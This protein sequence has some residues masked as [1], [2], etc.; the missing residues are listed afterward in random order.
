MIASATKPADDLVGRATR[1]TLEANA[2][3][4]R[5]RPAW[6]KAA[7]SASDE[8]PVAPP[9]TKTTIGAAMAEVTSATM[10]L[11]MKKRVAVAPIPNERTP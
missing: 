4:S 5:S 2:A 3:A 1:C 6:A 11:S 10:T 8:W 9:N 7:V